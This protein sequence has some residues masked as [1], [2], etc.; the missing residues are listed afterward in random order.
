MN[1]CIRLLIIIV[2]ML[3]VL[4]IPFIPVYAADVSNVQTKLHSN[5]RVTVKGVA[6]TD[7]G[8]PVTIKIVDPNGRLEYVD[9]KETGQLG[10]FRFSYFMSDILPGNYQVILN[11]LDSSGPVTTSFSYEE[12]NNLEGLSI[13]NGSFDKAF[14]PEVTQYEVNVGKE[15]DSIIVTPTA[16]DS[17]AT[18]KVNGKVVVS[19]QHSDPVRLQEGANTVS[20]TVT[21]VTGQTKTYTITVNREIDLS[22]SIEANASIDDKKKVTVSGTISSGP[23]QLITLKITDPKGNLEYIGNTAS[24]SGG[25]FQLSY[26]LANNTPGRYYAELGALGLS[27]QA[28]TYFD[29][30]AGVELQDLVINDISLN[31]DF[32][33]NQMSY[34]A[35]VD[36]SVNSVTVTPIAGKGTAGIKVNEMDIVSGH[37]SEPITIDEG[38]NIDVTAFSEDSVIK[39]TYTITVK[40]VSSLNKDGYVTAGMDDKK[41]VTVSGAIGSKAGQ[42]IAVMIRD[43]NGEI[44]YLNTTKTTAGGEFSFA[45]PMRNN[46]KGKYTVTVGAVG[47]ERLIASFNYYELNLKDLAMDNG[48]M[49]PAFSSNRTEYNVVV[50]YD[51]DAVRVTPTTVDPN[52]IVEVNGK[53]VASGEKSESIGLSVGDNIISVV[54]ASPDGAAAKTYEI[55]VRREARKAREAVRR[56]QLVS[57][58][59][60]LSSLAVTGSD[61]HVLAMDFAPDVTE[62]NLEADS[63]VDYVYVT[64]TAADPQA[65]IE[66]S[67]NGSEFQEVE[68]GQNS[69]EFYLE[70]GENT[71]EVKVTAPDSST[72][73]YAITIIL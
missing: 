59:A 9:S 22:T 44:E 48:K 3:I 41:V 72:K 52:A 46:V 50:K 21:A 58:N 15:V 6:G 20:V 10:N 31:P 32:D 24:T 61:G 18:I 19:G 68:N 12:D 55:N 38:T 28:T 53:T 69:D 45:Y 37:T 42:L 26:Y 27:N 2:F 33:P 16:S 14:S 34:T 35:I 67:F 1:K 56:I 49:A 11:T 43:P 71:I 13:S 8:T 64:P 30:D 17:Y 39:K 29:Y 66:V 73:T 57:S 47:I 7:A 36:K 25:Q 63:V 62:Y 40:K 54:V 65:V 4:S 70:G 23:G 60:D 5:K 51:T